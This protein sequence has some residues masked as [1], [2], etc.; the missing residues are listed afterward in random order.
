VGISKEEEKK[1]KIRR[2]IKKK[3]GKKETKKMREEKQKTERK[4]EERKK[5]GEEKKE[6]EKQRM[7]EREEKERERDRGTYIYKYKIIFYIY[8]KVFFNTSCSC[9]FSFTSLFCGRVIKSDCGQFRPSGTNALLH[10]K[11]L[12]SLDI[13]EILHCFLRLF[14]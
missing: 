2:E 9:R 1:G 14:P 5:E 7:K 4:K 8:A 12:C 10:V 11:H 6:D 3:G 13:G